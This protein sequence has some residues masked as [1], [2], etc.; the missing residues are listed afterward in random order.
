MD[1]LTCFASS[2]HTFLAT[3][4]TQDTENF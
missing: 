3:E 1:N 4:F 2:P